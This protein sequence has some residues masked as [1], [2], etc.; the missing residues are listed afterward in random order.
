VNAD[1]STFQLAQTIFEPDLLPYKYHNSLTPFILHAYLPMKM[2]LTECSE[3]LAY[4]LQVP[5]NHP[6]ESIQH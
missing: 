3:P 2:E 5:A 4:K 1:G 6:E